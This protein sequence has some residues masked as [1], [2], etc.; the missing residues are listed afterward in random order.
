MTYTA[1]LLILFST[2][3]HAT[4]NMFSR[5]LRISSS[6]FSIGGLAV[7]LCL[8]PIIV[9]YQQFLP[10]ISLDSLAIILLSSAFQSIYYYGLAN[11]YQHGNLSIAYPLVR[12]IPI[13]LVL[14][15]VFLFDHIENISNQAI[16]SAVVIVI[17]CILLPMQHFKDLQFSNYANRMSCFVLVAALGTAGYSI[18]DSIGMQRLV[19]SS[20][21]TNPFAV[22]FCYIYLQVFFTSILLGLISIS[23][24]HKRRGFI[25]VL[26]EQK[27]ISAA[28]CGMSMLAYA[29]I[30]VAMT[31]VTNVAYVVA[32]R[33][34]SIP[35]AFLLGLVLL[36][37]ASYPIRWIAISLIIAGL[38]VN[39]LY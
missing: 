3:V 32:L 20:P 14:I 10:N 38:I 30:L 12:S 24:V 34:A 31:L 9:I 21:D 19:T 15:Y 1:L 17:G 39:G 35:I 28:I 23:S 4:W 6:S 7:C 36:R 22:S 11:A 33:Q 18:I 26:K 8:L 13:I 29:P 2:L 37:E 25:K 27:R 16:G 5:K